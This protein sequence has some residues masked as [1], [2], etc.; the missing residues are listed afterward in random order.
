MFCGLGRGCFVIAL[1]EF[2]SCSHRDNVGGKSRYSIEL[3]YSWEDS[4]EVN[5]R[6]VG[7]LSVNNP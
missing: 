2:V 6:I 7:E 1:D 4:P 3:V 5:H